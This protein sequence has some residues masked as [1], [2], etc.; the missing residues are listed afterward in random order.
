MHQR[1]SADED[2][3]SDV[4]EDDK[5]VKE[6]ADNK[7]ADNKAVDDAA[8]DS[9]WRHAPSL[10]PQL[11]S[12]CHQ[13]CCQQRSQPRDFLGAHSHSWVR[14]NC[15]GLSPEIEERKTEE[16][17]SFV[18]CQ[19]NDNSFEFPTSPPLEL[20]LGVALDFAELCLG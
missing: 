6:A 13:L 12:W 19:G 1:Q 15:R 10:G 18:I 14:R 20:N 3:E 5:A 4:K 11:S 8:M 16:A 7:A 17:R 9:L 2:D